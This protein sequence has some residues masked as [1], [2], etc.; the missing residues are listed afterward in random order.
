M[1][2]IKKYLKKYGEP[3]AII[4]SSNCQ[5]KK[6]M[7]WGFDS[8]C[9][10]LNDS[11]FIDNIK[12]KGNPLEILDSIID[13]WSYNSTNPVNVIGYISYDFKN[14]LFPHLKLKNPN[15]N[16]VPYVWFA[17]PRHVIEFDEPNLEQFF[18]E[19]FNLDITSDIPNQK[20]YVDVISKIKHHLRK[21]DVYQINYTNPKQFKITGSP[22]SIYSRLRSISNPDNGYYINTGFNHILSLSPESFFTIKDNIIE[23]MPIKGTRN[24]VEN[25]QDNKKLI[26]ELK[27][28]KKDKAEHLM[29]V[30]LLRNDIGKICNYGTVNVS[31]LFNVKTYKNIHHMVSKVYGTLKNNTKFSDIIYA[32]FPG[33][34]IT[35]AP[36]EK[37]I[38][39][40]DSLE[41]YNRNIYTGTI[42]HMRNRNEMYFNI[43]IRTLIISKN[44]GSYC[45]GGGIVWDSD[46]IDEWEEAN[47]KSNIINKL[48]NTK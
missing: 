10:Y 46:A 6:Y 21:G 14:N 12:V 13:D 34:S 5:S 43:A 22:L 30:D 28:S 23:S 4:D 16:N 38:E 44:I 36:K 19:K 42:G 26:D 2:T 33:G 18:N 1:Y 39:I 45:V 35:G 24:K 41:Q 9:M 20:Q 29:I 37:A 3:D 17:K 47:I 11:F 25:K 32:L 15:T 31:D 7:I 8:T 40:I 48:I 27:N